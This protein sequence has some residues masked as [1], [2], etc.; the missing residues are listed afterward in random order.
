M[1]EFFLK[2]SNF[3]LAHFSEDNTLKVQ[4]SK[5]VVTPSRLRLGLS[6]NSKIS[7]PLHQNV[8]FN[9]NWRVFY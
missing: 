3:I 8:S 6:R 1:S 4:F 5:K 9:I 7:K 2:C